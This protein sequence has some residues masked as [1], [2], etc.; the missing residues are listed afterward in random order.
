MF[1][2]AAKLQKVDLK[3]FYTNPTILTN[4]LYNAWKFFRY[5][6]IVNYIDESLELEALGCRVDWYNE[7]YIIVAKSLELEN[8]NWRGIKERGRVP[9]AVEVIRRLKMMV[10]DEY[11]IAGVLKGPFTLLND[12]TEK[13]VR[14]DLLQ[15]IANAEFEICQAYC[16][17]GADLIL[18]FEKRLPPDEET[19][20]EYMKNLAPLRNVANFFE[21][22]LILSLK[23]TGLPQTLNI[24]Q[25]SVD[26]IILEDEQSS[27]NQVKVPLGLA[28]PNDLFYD[29]KKIT[30]FIQQKLESGI[31]PFLLI[32]REEVHDIQVHLLK[33]SINA[34]KSL[35][36][37]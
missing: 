19:L 2:Y 33:N 6:G 7:R 22:R 1:S 3:T 35:K 4:T 9:I 36:L 5:D 18:L 15:R 13:E 14:G 34:L 16:E 11:I 8:L 24:L 10:R 27:L 23:E 32:T 17:A 29:G 28:I 31:K 37:G 25:G 26:G 12:L 30:H 21:S 20:H